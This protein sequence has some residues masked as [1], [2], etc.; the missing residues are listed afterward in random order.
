MT[1]YPP[2]VWRNILLIG[3]FIKMYQSNTESLDSVRAFVRACV[4]MCVIYP[5][6]TPAPHHPDSCQ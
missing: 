5:S 4:R 6:Q 3:L 1:R 2:K